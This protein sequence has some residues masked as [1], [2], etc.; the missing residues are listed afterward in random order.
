[1]PKHETPMVEHYWRSVCGGTLFL[2]FPLV[3]RSSNSSARWLDG[4]IVPDLDEGKWHWSDA[5]R[6][7]YTPESIVEGRH[8]VAVQAK[9]DPGRLSM[10]L[11]GQTFFSV[12]LLKRLNPA[13][14]HG[15][16]LCHE[17]DAALSGV[18]LAYPDMEVAIDP[19]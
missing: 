6:N 2:E 18:F 12:E 8:V 15:V 5:A 7:G 13:S 19:L 17:D 14:V 10:G 9:H 1:M 11:L 4:L 16:A 3:K